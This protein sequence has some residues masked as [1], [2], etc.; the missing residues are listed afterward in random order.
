MVKRKAV[1][2]RSDKKPPVSVN[3]PRE[4]VPVLHWEPGILTGYRATDQPWSYYFSSLFKL[5]NE[6][7]N[8]WSHLIAPFIYIYVIWS[9]HEDLNYWNDPSSWGI[10]VLGVTSVLSAFGSAAAHLLH[11]R[12]ELAH[13]TMFSIDYMCIAVYGYGFGTMIYHTSGN[14]LFYAKMGGIFPYIH[15]MFATNITLCNCLARVLYHHRQCK[16]RKLLQAGSCALSILFC[17]SIPIFRVYSCWING[18][19]TT[20]PIINHASYHIFTILNALLFSLH[21][22]ERSFPGYCDIWGHGHQL[23]HISV[24]FGKVFQFY[25]SYR[26][27]MVLPRE[28][29]LLAQPNFYHMLANLIAVILLN[30][31]IILFFY[32]KFKHA[33]KKDK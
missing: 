14:E 7:V 29:L 10:L 26:D 32:P 2:P 9:F 20:D 24:I 8:V 28:V 16:R 21:Q 33:V 31:A 15:T 30:V 1:P 23:F 27:L 19:L 11:S 12:S 3:L 18:T 6:T 22:P 4:Q 13:F 17:E 25:A 5:H